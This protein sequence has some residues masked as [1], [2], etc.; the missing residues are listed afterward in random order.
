M[1]AAGQSTSPA[2]FG[3]PAH[4]LWTLVARGLEVQRGGRTVLRS[5]DI[6]I[7]CGECVCIIG[8]NGAGKSSLILALLGQLAPARGTVELDGRSV[9]R[10][11]PR[12]RGRWASYVPQ[13][14]GP[15]AGYTVY[16][17]VSGG[18]FPHVGPLAP[19]SSADLD[20]V[21]RALERCRLTHLAERPFTHLS[22]GERQ[23]SLIAS[24]IAQ[25]ADV[26]FLDEPNTALDPEYQIELVSLL[27]EWYAAG[28][29]YVIVTHD[30]QIPAVLGCTLIA[31]RDGIV[32]AHGPAAEVLDPVRLR[33]IFDADFESLLR[34]DG[35]RAI[36]PKL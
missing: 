18:R 36:L 27:R 6:S 9:A 8:P 28:R 35:A 7:H 4:R 5:I 1:T 33:A 13:A 20:H 22:S 3:P 2:V 11:N 29:T 23:K 34:S 24:A 14:R 26:M 19:L 15:I 17:V 32:A 31:L 10:M 12:S 30:L 21:H 25:D 16:D